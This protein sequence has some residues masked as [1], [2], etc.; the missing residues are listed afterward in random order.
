MPTEELNEIIL[1]AVP[2]GWKKQAYLQGWG[3]LIL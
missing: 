2:N 1:Q 3:V